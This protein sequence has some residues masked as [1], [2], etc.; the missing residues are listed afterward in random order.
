MR[1]TRIGSYLAGVLSA[2]HALRTI[3]R[4]TMWTPR[5]EPKAPRKI[6]PV[7]IVVLLVAVLAA[8]GLVLYLMFSGPRMRVQPKLLPYEA[9]VPV[10]PQGTVP[11]FPVGA[12]PLPAGRNPLADTERTRRIGQAYYNNYCTFCHGKTGRGDGPVGQS[13]VPVPTDLT[14]PAVQD[15]SDSDLYR[16]MLTGVGHAPVLDYVVDPNAA[17]YLV[18][19]VRSLRG[20]D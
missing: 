19:Y 9:L 6:G 3:A 2:V 8:G 1:R 13:Y 11:V 17:W 4:A 7:Q 12:Q 15:L 16:S 18:G 10:M 14:A 5:P 20:K